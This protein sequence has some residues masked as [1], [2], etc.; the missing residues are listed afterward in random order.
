MNEED[1]DNN[2]RRSGYDRLFWEAAY[3]ILTS[4]N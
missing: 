2:K 4:A 1:L 3:F